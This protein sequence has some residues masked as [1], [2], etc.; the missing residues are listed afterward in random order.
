MCCHQLQWRNIME[1]LLGCQRS[2]SEKI[3]HISHL[4]ASYALPLQVFIMSLSTFPSL[5]DSTDLLDFMPHNATA[6]SGPPS[7]P[8][9]TDVTKSSI[10]L[11]WEPG[12][13]A[14]SPVS[15]YVI[16]AFGYVFDLCPPAT[17][18]DP[19]LVLPLWAFLWAFNEARAVSSRI[20]W[21]AYNYLKEIFFIILVFEFEC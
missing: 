9:V 16:E 21:M 7:K 6:L 17:F 4:Y 8:L 19:K 3:I 1:C 14:G 2:A 20:F 12:P 15:S 11:S 18:S 10:S 5:S 13:E